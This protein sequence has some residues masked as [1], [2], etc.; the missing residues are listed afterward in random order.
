M[1]HRRQFLLELPAQKDVQKR[2]H[3][4]VCGSEP[5]A[6]FF[7]QPAYYVEAAVVGRD[8]D[9]LKGVRD[10]DYVV[11]SEWH[12]EHNDNEKNTQFDL[13]LSLVVIAARVSKRLDHLVCN[14]NIAN[15]NDHTDKPEE[16]I[17]VNHHCL[18]EVESGRSFQHHTRADCCQIG[19]WSVS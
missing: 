16:H 9:L 14:A 4:D 11:R 19:Y 18:V 12:K 13:L 5:E 3:T 6:D 17:Q 1:H 7:G 2:V 10:P 8:D 15:R